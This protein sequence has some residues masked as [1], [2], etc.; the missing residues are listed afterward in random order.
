M[1]DIPSMHYRRGPGRKR[2]P[3]FVD[4]PR[5]GTTTNTTTGSSAAPPPHHALRNVRDERTNER[6][7]YATNRKPYSVV[8]RQTRGQTH[9]ENV[10]LYVRGARGLLDTWVYTTTT[11]KRTTVGTRRA[12]GRVQ[13]WG[14]TRCCAMALCNCWRG[15]QAYRTTCPP[16]FNRLQQ[17]QGRGSRG[18]RLARP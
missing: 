7:T 18:R 3:N 9:D 10:P 16:L 8:Y 4:L 2:R 13:P 11:G 17:R 12:Y 14:G 15:T 5:H 1:L 6:R